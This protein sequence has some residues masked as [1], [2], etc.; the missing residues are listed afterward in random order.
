MY[1]ARC[2]S[3][4]AMKI[5]IAAGADVNANNS[6]G[7]TVLMWGITDLAKVQLLL[8]N[9]ADVNARSKQGKT[10]LLLAVHHDGSGEIV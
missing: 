3:V 5:L 7:A 1:A 6:F 8:H 2:G 9:E 10:P 4:E